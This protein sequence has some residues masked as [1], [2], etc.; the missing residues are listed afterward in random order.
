MTFLKNVFKIYCADIRK[1][2]K[3]VVAIIICLG[4]C[5]LPSL[6]AWVNILACW[7]PYSNTGDIKVGIVNE[8]E[9]AS[10]MDMRVEI[11]AE[12]TAEL[13]DNKKLGWTFFDTAEEGIEQCKK[14]QRL[15][16]HHRAEGFFPK[17]ADAGG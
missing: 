3:S 12:L 4:L 17:A 13:K 14:G 1:I 16:D 6:Y 5:L 15:R 7:D 2:S 11:G 10:I 8:D 9:G